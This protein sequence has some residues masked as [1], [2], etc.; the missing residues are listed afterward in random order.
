M[1]KTLAVCYLHFIDKVVLHMIIAFV[2]SLSSDLGKKVEWIKTAKAVENK[3][4]LIRVRCVRALLRHHSSSPLT[5]QWSTVP[6]KG[7]FPLLPHLVLPV[8]VNFCAML[9]CISPA[10]MAATVDL[11][12][13]PPSSAR[14][15][16]WNA[17]RQTSCTKLIPDLMKGTNPP[18]FYIAVVY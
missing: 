14:Y 2:P 12:S 9:C 8:I 17:C 11:R 3:I 5:V 7:I 13:P 1:L 10:M 15:R 4:Q 6:L 16:A 18:L